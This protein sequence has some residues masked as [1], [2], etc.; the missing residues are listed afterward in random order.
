M[1]VCTYVC[2]FV[3]CLYVIVIIS[4]FDCNHITIN[5][6][7]SLGKEGKEKWNQKGHRKIEWDSIL[8]DELRNKRN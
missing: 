6:D 5:T 7:L 1:Y 3:E 4:S 2:I 8:K